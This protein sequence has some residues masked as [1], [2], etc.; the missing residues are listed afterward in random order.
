MATVL[1]P[2][3]F[4]NEANI[5]DFEQIST[6]R[7]FLF[8]IICGYTVTFNNFQSRSP[9]F[10]FSIGFLFTCAK[11]VLLK[12]HRQYGFSKEQRDKVKKEQAEKKKAAAAAIP[13]RMK[14]ELASEEDEC[15]VEQKRLKS[16]LKG[17]SVME[18]KEDSL[19]CN[20]VGSIVGLQSEEIS[21]IASEYRMLKGCVWNMVVILL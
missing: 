17:I 6:G 19:S 15:V 3:P 20:T 7:C 18:G 14:S 8:K 11:F 21:R 9:F 12:F 2:V 5:L 16:L 4:C 10:L 1:F 13:G